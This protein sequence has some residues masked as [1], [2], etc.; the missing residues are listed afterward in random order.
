MGTQSSPLWEDASRQGGTGLPIATRGS[1]RG[2]G[3]GAQC[4][5][6]SSRGEA[7]GS[8][9]PHREEGWRRQQWGAG[10]V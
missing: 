7:V 6:G 3:R 10:K 5:C 9:A 4:G 8:A 2:A 1:P